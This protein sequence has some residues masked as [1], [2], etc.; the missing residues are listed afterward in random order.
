MLL[1]SIVNTFEDVTENLVGQENFTNI[2]ISREALAFRG[3]R[4]SQAGT[5]CSTQYKHK[6][7]MGRPV[8]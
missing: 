4:V 2:A 7:K 5:L 6:L 8:V 1:S 3:E